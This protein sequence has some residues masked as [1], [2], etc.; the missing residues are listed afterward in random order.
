MYLYSFTDSSI[1]QGLV[2]SFVT[3]LPRFIMAVIILIVGIVISKI[4]ANIIKKTLLAVN[5]DKLGE[6]LSEIDFIEKSNIKI[7]FSTILSRVF[8][9]ILVLFF[10]VAATEALG[11]PAVSQ[12]VSDL[13][14]LIPSLI[15]AGIILVLGTIMADVL[16]NVAQTALESLGIPSARMIASFVFYFLLINIVI[17][18]FTQ[19]QI[20]TEFLSQNISIVIGGIVLAFAIGYGLASRSSMSNFLASYYSNG[21][22]DVGDTITLDGV[23]GRIVEMDKSALTLV[24][25]ESRRIIF[26]LNQVSNSR[27]EIHN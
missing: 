21:K 15:V 8:Y 7:K 26:P 2:S 13:F 27:I 20:N 19:A 17:S 1:L 5:I 16:K 10:L 25:E 22:F 6:K 14:N 4:I 24:T 9:Y 18:A 11:M 3:G 12:L 23:T